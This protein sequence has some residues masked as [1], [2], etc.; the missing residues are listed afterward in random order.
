MLEE[1]QASSPKAP[2]LCDPNWPL[3]KPLGDSW[4]RRGLSHQVSVLYGG[5]WRPCPPHLCW[6]RW[7]KVLSQGWGTASGPPGSSLCVSH[8]P[9]S[10]EE[11][12]SGHI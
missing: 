10:L 5:L 11:H 12:L 3:T 9:S 4:G 6:H 8:S 7:E 1:A 2:D